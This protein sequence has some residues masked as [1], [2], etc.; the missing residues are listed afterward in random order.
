MKRVC[1]LHESWDGAV[2]RMQDACRIFNAKT[3]G[4]RYK[5]KEDREIL[6]KHPVYKRSYSSLLSPLLLS[7]SAHHTFQATPNPRKKLISNLKHTSISKMSPPYPTSSQI[8]EIFESRLDQSVFNS[9]FADSASIIIVGQDEAAFSGHYKSTQHFDEIV[10]DRLSATMKMDTVRI[11]AV[12]VIGGGESASAAVEIS[13]NCTTKLGEFDSLP[14]ITPRFNPSVL[15]HLG[16]LG[17]FFFFPPLSVILF[18]HSRGCCGGADKPFFC[19]YVELVRFNSDGK[20]EQLKVFPDQWL[21]HS[22]LEEHEG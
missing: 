22:H 1:R 9:H 20:I 14:T 8:K 18:T 3:R 10:Y 16:S 13:V 5:R 4:E 17:G 19:E 2:L 15:D 11:E 21:L 7:S 12:Q 6:Q